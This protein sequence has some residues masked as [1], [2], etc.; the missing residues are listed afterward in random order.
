MRETAQIPEKVG[1]VACRRRTP[2]PTSPSRFRNLLPIPI[3]LPPRLISPPRTSPLPK[4]IPPAAAA[5]RN[6][7]GLKL[8]TWLAVG[9]RPRLLRWKRWLQQIGELEPVLQAETDAQIRKRS[10]AIR[11]R[12]K[13]GEP[14]KTLLPEA[15]ALVREAGRRTLGMR[16]YDVQMIGGMSLV[17]RLYL[18]RCKPAKA[19]R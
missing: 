10:L 19:K 4:G 15:Y 5:V 14:L 8:S 13:A 18:P 3:R 11:Y 9:T 16:H 7:G 6:D 2:K 17:R 1:L 12:A